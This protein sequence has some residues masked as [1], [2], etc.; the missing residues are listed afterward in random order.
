MKTIPPSCPEPETGRR[1]WRS[2]DQVA[3]TPEFRHWLERE[4]PQGASE[5]TDPVSRRHFVKIMSAS[6]ALAGLGLTGCRRPEFK[7][8]PFAQQPEGYIHGKAQYFASA[9]PTRGGA[10][11][12]VVKSHDGRPVK[13]E[14]NPLHPDSNGGTDRYAQAA[15]LDLYDP[16]RAQRFTRGGNNVDAAAARDFV[17]AT[18]QQFA[19]K[20]GAGLAVLMEPGSCP[21][22]ARLMRELSVKMPKARWFSHDPLGFDIHR[23]AASEICGKP[24]QPRYHFDKAD[25]ILSLDCD[26]LGTEPDGHNSIRQFAKGRRVEKPG[27]TMS[28]LYVIESLM[29]LT[30]ANADHRLR[31]SSSAVLDV[32][33]AF[34]VAVGATQ[35]SPEVDGVDPKWITE[36]AK[37]LSRHKGHALVVAGTGQPMAVHALAHAMNAALGAVGKTV[38]YLPADDDSPESLQDLVAALNEGA[39]KTLVILGGNPAYSTPAELNWTD[40]LAK[41]GTVVRL[42]YYEDE[43]AVDADWHLP[44]A[45]FLES[46]GDAR[47]SDGT[48]VPIQPLIAP[49]FDGVSELDVLVWLAG[50]GAVSAY[51]AVRETFA[52]VSDATDVE[53][54]WRK[55]L[56]DGFLA[57]S[58][59]TPVSVTPQSS[60]IAS[61]IGGAAAGVAS[62]NNLEVVF[63]RDYSVDD[64]RY[65][66]NG[67]LQEL[68]DPITK[69]T[70]DNAVLVSRKTAKALGCENN[71][72]VKVQLGDHSVEGPIWVQPGQADHVLGLALG[73]GRRQAGRV[74]TGTGFNVYPI[75]PGGGESI[76]LGATVTRTGARYPLSNPQEHWSME[77][78]PIIREANLEQFNEHPNFAAGMNLHEPPKP[79]GAEQWPTSLYPNPME[80]EGTKSEHHQWGMSVDLN[81]CVGCSTCVVACQSENNIPIVGKDQVARG[82][83]MHWLRL[84]RYY[85]TDAEQFEERNNRSIASQAVLAPSEEQQFE[86]WIDDVQVVTQPMMCQHCENAP[87]ESVCPVNATA[88][89]HE[90]LNVMV[91]NRCVGTRYCS[92]NCPYKVRRFNF[93]D[94]NK[95]PLDGLYKGPLATRAQDEWELIKMVKNPE[96]TVRMR[97]V[98]EKCTF[99]IQRIESAKIDQKVKAGASGDV[100]VP[101]GTIQTACQQAC[102]AGAIVFGNL[103]DPESRVSKLKH[104]TRDYSVLEFL[105]VKPRLT[106]LAK[107]RNPNPAMP[108]FRESPFSLEEHKSK[109]G[110]PFRHHGDAH[111]GGADAAHGAEKGGH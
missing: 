100:V 51:D 75:R 60:R 78:R 56:H 67:W 7:L 55:F 101:D 2:L 62:A 36:C 90:G 80:A 34:G 65:N 5:L 1:Y 83:E 84:D 68:P 9:M 4:F 95:R 66:N 27:D 58:A 81:A 57:D 31:L 13:L 59:S 108:D 37:D 24:V 97:G 30:G 17:T 48:L 3:D 98:M 77:G 38:D 86:E 110:D 22:R 61:L 23:K 53:D 20:Q 15:I 72:V 42:G 94:Y 32:A 69:I 19:A 40:A 12:L 54:A 49:L 64:G 21:T 76:A 47:T 79:E 39:V 46:W 45:H 6:F 63:R 96:V 107:V 29:T 50:L 14:G 26:F 104:Q 71:D 10:I 11:P 92:N 87:C 25:V 70:W 73:Y 44:M 102:P 28:R 16:D 35:G 41:A 103:L 74:G 91:Y 43:S 82:R 106:Y 52:Q 93:F 88:H 99:C 8:E 109:M 85:S 33:R 111:H 89:D 18:G 105:M